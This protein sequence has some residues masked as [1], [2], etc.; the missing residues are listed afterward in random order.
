MRSVV[1]VLP[2]STCAMT[3][4]LRRLRR[5]AVV[6]DMV[7]LS[8]RDVVSRTRR[9]A[10]QPSPGDHQGGQLPVRFP[11]PAHGRG[12]ATSRR[13]GIVAVNLSYVRMAFFL[14]SE[15]KQTPGDLRL[16]GSFGSAGRNGPPTNGSES[17]QL[18]SV[19]LFTW[20]TRARKLCMLFMMG[21]IIRRW[22][23]LYTE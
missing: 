15:K 14:Q 7:V 9:S 11:W 8:W 5:G 6:L 21:V 10:S 4:M 2:A 16:P 13:S 20:A 1:V 22:R 18:A 17:T 12:E 3:P 19:A 23:K